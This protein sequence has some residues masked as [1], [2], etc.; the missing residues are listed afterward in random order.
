[1]YICIH[2]YVL[3][4]RTVLRVCYSNY[5]NINSIGNEIKSIGYYYKPERIIK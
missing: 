1:M 5:Y 4:V 3:N 2:I